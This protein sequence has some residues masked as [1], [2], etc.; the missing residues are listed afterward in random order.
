MTR[1]SGYVSWHAKMEVTNFAHPLCCDRPRETSISMA[2]ATMSYPPRYVIYRPYPVYVQPPPPQPPPVV[3]HRVIVRQP[4][5]RQTLIRE[6][7][8]FVSE[9]EQKRGA[10]PAEKR[11]PSPGR[12]RRKSRS[13]DSSDSYDSDDSDDSDDSGR[14]RGRRKSPGK[15]GGK[16]GGKTGGKTGGKSDGEVTLRK[17]IRLNKKSPG[18]EKDKDKDRETDKKYEDEALDY[19]KKALAPQ[20][21]Y[22]HP[23]DC[24]CPP[25]ARGIV[26]GSLRPKQGKEGAK[27]SAGAQA[28]GRAGAQAKTTTSSTSNK[29]TLQREKQEAKD[30]QDLMARV[31]DHFSQN[32]VFIG[33]FER[34]AVS[35]QGD[36]TQRR[37]AKAHVKAGP[38]N[39]TR[40][41]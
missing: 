40:V 15:K 39:G 17:N 34:L 31:G 37:G 10:R 4:S 26:P 32:G 38:A 12:R 11:T 22:Y 30:L 6:V 33:S 18:K 3:R 9:K 29:S 24:R 28:K 16:K 23:P 5:A 2:T 35:Q 14:R 27:G 8:V 1:P 41:A 7:P 36:D 20:I 19:A 25:C 13:S 21:W